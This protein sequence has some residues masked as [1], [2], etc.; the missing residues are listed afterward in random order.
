MERLSENSVLNIKNK[1]HSVTAEIVVPQLGGRRRDHCA[2]RQYWRLEPHAK[3]GKLKYCYN[4]LGMQHFYVED[5]CSVLSPGD[6]QVRMEFGYDGGGLGKGGTATLYVDGKKAGEAAKLLCY[7]AT[8]FLADDGSR[9]W[10]LIP[11][12]RCHRIMERAETSSPATSKASRLQSQPTPWAP[13]IWFRRRRQSGSPSRD[14]KTRAVGGSNGLPPAP[15]AVGHICGEASSVAAG[16][17]QFLSSHRT[18]RT[19]CESGTLRHA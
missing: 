7:R 18:S 1:S 3:E 6:H 15:V 10:M 19:D 13:I 9:C 11:A 12:R 4:L 5:I 16:G 14:S 17:G 2:R 8:S